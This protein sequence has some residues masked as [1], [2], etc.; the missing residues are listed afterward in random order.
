MTHIM[1][2]DRLLQ[3][4]QGTKNYESPAESLADEVL[5]NIEAR[6]KLVKGDEI[7]FERVGTSFIFGYDNENIYQETRLINEVIKS[8]ALIDIDISHY[9][10]R[11]I[12]SET[13]SL[14]IVHIHS[15]LG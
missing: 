9:S 15:F 3:A 5:D 7:H 10:V 11:Y 8:A 4:M 2:N 12:E 13:L 14:T 1:K 6:I